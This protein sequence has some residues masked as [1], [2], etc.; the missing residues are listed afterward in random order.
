MALLRSEWQTPNGQ[1]QSDL[2]H[3]RVLD[4]ASHAAPEQY[5]SL[6][7]L[8]AVLRRY[9]GMIALIT[10]S[11]VLLAFLACLLLTPKYNS[12]ATL[13]IIPDDAS[14]AGGGS[15]G[16]PTS[17]VKTEVTTDVTILQNST[18]AL[19]TIDKLNLLSHVPYKRT[20][21][22]KEIGRP[23]D[24][25]PL[26]RQKLLK[27]F[28]ASL[29]AEPVEDS[30][31]I[32]VT[33][34]D[35]DP[36][37]AASVANTLSEMFI[38]DYVQRRLQSSSQ[39][40]FWLNKE[41]EGSK[42][43]LQES[44]Q[45]LADFQR[46]SGLAGINLGGTIPGS[47]GVTVESH[48]AVVDRLNA[49]NQELD[50][51]EANRI[52]SEG[53]YRLLKDQS[54]EV[55]LGLGP[56]ASLV[57][58]SAIG[59]TGG[60]DLL[61]TLRAQ[62]VALKV[63]YADLETKYGA[64]NPRLIELHNQMDTINSSIKIELDNITARAYNSYQFAKSS[65]DT[66]KA[67]L[68]KQQEEV[69][70]LSDNTAK[71]QVLSQQALSNRAQYQSLF[72]QVQ[73][74]S[75]QQGIHATRLSIVDRAQVTGLPSFPNYPLTLAVAMLLGILIGIGVAFLRQ[76]MDVSVTL[77]RD[78]EMAVHS[79]VLAFLPLFSGKTAELSTSSNASALLS[80][81]DSPL[82]EAFRVLR[83]A[84]MM[85]SPAE[86]GKTLLITSPL[87]SDGKTTIVYNLGIALAQQGSRVLLI[88]GDLRHADLH[89]Y[90]DIVNQNGLSDALEAQQT[91]VQARL[92]THPSVENL[93]LLPAGARPGLP[94]ELF[95]GPTLDLLVTEMRKEFDW[96]LID[97][98]PVLPVAD[99]AVLAAKVDAIL[100]VVRAGITSRADL[101]SMNQLLERTGAPIVGYVLNGVPQ[102]STR[103]HSY[104]SPRSARKGSYA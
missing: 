81:P 21:D 93:V 102:S 71:L 95:T 91:D 46:S 65:E 44:E 26:T 97:S 63:Q 13:E 43:R 30:R 73:A 76:S 10:L 68:A 94:S 85:S 11:M 47:E 29:K 32:Q 70:K 52:S 49:L 7:D 92:K 14:A 100:P 67:Q 18:L 33:F 104:G 75:V 83:T 82:A 28:E 6:S 20:I 103:L 3:H 59:Q 34:R 60:L 9:R 98:P 86:P 15:S 35:R 55:V 79:P 74:A 16:A 41:L 61:R 23:L 77:P 24:Q 57:G 22:K 84:L 62:Q 64:K 40:S 78:V 54:P 42:K 87:G 31:L 90:F 36:V 19:Q 66:V 50:T 56:I 17:D 8:L 51:A 69:N 39:F 38:E 72:S 1:R 96:I 37:V 48:N 99:A 27:M 4:A 58:G 80:Q 89:H 25:A 53:V 2:Q 12:V 45:A 101:Q 88:D 5:E